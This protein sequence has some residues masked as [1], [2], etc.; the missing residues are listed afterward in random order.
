MVELAFF[1]TFTDDMIDL[2]GFFDGLN[3]RRIRWFL[4]IDLFL[5]GLILHLEVDGFGRLKRRLLFVVGDGVEIF[6]VLVESIHIYLFA[7][8]GYTFALF[9]F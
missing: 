9:A 5:K 4:F 3:G 1:K 8:G 2:F 7:N 6:F